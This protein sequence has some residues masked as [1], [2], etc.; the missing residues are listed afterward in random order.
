VKGIPVVLRANKDETMK[1]KV[2]NKYAITSFL[3]LA[4]S[5]V[6]ISIAL[7]NNLGEFVTASL[8]ISGMICVVIG[9]F[10]LTFSKGE[11][12]DPRLL[13]LLPAQGSIN[14][15]TIMQSYG[16]SGNA[17]FLPPQ[18]TGESRVMQFNPVLIYSGSEGYPK[19]SFRTTGPRG[20]VTLPSCNLLIKDLKRR[21][22]LVIP[23]TEEALTQLL[24]ET[25]ED[26]FKFTPRVSV[27]WHGNLVTINFQDYS[28]NSCEL[29][30]QTSS[31]C[32][33]M[34]PC[35]MCSLCGVL[36]AQGLDKIVTLDTCTVSLSST[37]VT[38]VFSILP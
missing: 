7:I 37:D 26:V 28:T 33:S 18:V 5:A 24:R 4:A 25:I 22:E 12:Y 15:C 35:P 3:L 17:N 34:N 21:N 29:L 30:A 20:I 1:M 27:I 14:L 38:A 23:D 13:G 31:L 16:I 32:C 36:I 19:G 11:P 6:F 8:V 2:P 10:S 9:I